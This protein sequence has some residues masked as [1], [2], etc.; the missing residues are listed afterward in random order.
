MRLGVRRMAVEFQTKL[1]QR[2]NQKKKMLIKMKKKNV[3]LGERR[4]RGDDELQ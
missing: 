2:K 4:L 1:W 3:Y